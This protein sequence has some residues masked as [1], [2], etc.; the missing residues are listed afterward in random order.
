MTANEALRFL[1]HEAA[2]CRDRDAHEAFCLLLPAL[3]RVLG[4]RALDDFA[5]L[6]F[7]R[8]F[9]RALRALNESP[10]VAAQCTDCQW[11]ESVRE[12]QL[13]RAWCDRCQRERVFERAESEAL[14]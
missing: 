12:C 4:L 6:E 14:A 3:C 7:E 1:A 13:E 2:R 10:L 11:P 9:H 5:A 8:D